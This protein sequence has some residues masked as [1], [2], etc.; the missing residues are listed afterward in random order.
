MLLGLIFKTSAQDTLIVHGG[1]KYM[2]EIAK[3]T[4]DYLH[5]YNYYSIPRNLV[6]IHTSKVERI[7]T[8]FDLFYKQRN[9]RIF[10]DSAVYKG[11]LVGISPTAIRYKK[12][13]QISEVDINTISSI[14]TQN[15]TAVAWSFAGG[16][17]FG[18]LIGVAVAGGKSATS[19]GVNFLSLGTVPYN[20]TNPTPYFFGGLLI[21][22]LVSGGTA[23][24]IKSNHPINYSHD[25]LKTDFFKFRTNPVGWQ[26]KIEVVKAKD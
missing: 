8:E 7:I 15:G 21:G 20:E 18:G 12:G 10:T 3:I 14:K 1:Q 6:K 4:S 11:R 24:V 2:V 16:G 22:A 19:A 25:A 13:N 23:L 9:V 17:L 5:Y 26:G